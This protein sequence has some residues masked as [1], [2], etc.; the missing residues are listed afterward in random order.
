VTHTDPTGMRPECGDCSTRAE[1][2]G[3]QVW[4]DSQ[5]TSSTTSEQTATPAV[6]QPDPDSI[7]PHVRA[8]NGCARRCGQ[9]SEQWIAR[10]EYVQECLGDYYPTSAAIQQC[11]HWFDL[12]QLNEEV[13]S[14]GCWPAKGC[15][16]LAIGCVDVGYRI[17]GLFPVG[18]HGGA[19]PHIGWGGGTPGWS[20][21]FQRPPS[22]TVRTSG[23]V[24]WTVCV[25]LTRDVNARTGEAETKFSV[26]VGN[27]GLGWYTEWFPFVDE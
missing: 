10:E 16:F 27:R 23:Q 13:C 18:L 19:G 26:G 5:P 6:N 7:R 3:L 1:Q 8:P 17:W 9:P 24:C 11:G 12:L 25:V 22:T 21:S 15:G 4:A 14:D 2:E 20:V